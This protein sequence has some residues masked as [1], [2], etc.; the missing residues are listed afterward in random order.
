VEKRERTVLLEALCILSFIGNGIAMALYLTAAT[1]NKM[2]RE[3]I[4]DWAAG[5]DFSHFTSPYF[6]LFSGLYLLSFTGV[7]LM[8]KIKKSGW[9]LYVTAQTIILFLPSLWLEESLIPSVNVIFTLLFVT[10]YTREIFK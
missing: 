10:L 5:G 8:W 2:A 3:W 6:L 1:W 7:L 9:F 4:A